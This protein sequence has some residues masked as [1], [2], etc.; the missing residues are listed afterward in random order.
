MADS[1]LAR[2][3][4]LLENRG[5]ILS[6]LKKYPNVVNLGV[7]LKEV[8]GKLTCILCYRV[9]VREKKAITKLMS[10]DIIPGQIDGFITDVIEY[11]TVEIAMD[12][13]PYRPLTGGVQIKNQYWVDNKTRGGGTLGCLVLN[14]N[15][16]DDEPDRIVGLTNEHV[17]ALNTQDTPEDNE[18][19]QPWKHICCCCCVKNVVGSVLRATKNNHLD[20]AVINLHDDIIAEIK[21]AGGINKIAEIGSYKGKAIA[22][23]GMKVKKRG[24]AT[25][26]T[27]GIVKDVAFDSNQI[28]IGPDENY[29]RFADFGD[30]GSIVLN[31]DDRIV[32]LLWATERNR[33]RIP[34]EPVIL[35]GNI[36][37]KIDPRIHGVATPI[38]VVETEMKIKI[39]SPPPVTPTIAIHPSDAKTF[40]VPSTKAG[41]TK[42]H[43]VTV[44]GDGDIILKVTFDQPVDASRVKWVSDNETIAISTPGDGT[45]PFTA[46]MSR[47]TPVGTMANISVTVDGYVVGDPAAVWIIWSSVLPD[48]KFFSDELKFTITPL[49]TSINYSAVLRYTI[50]PSYIIAPDIDTHDLPDLRGANVT[51]APNVPDSDSGV[52]QKGTDLSPGATAKWDGS[53]RLRC[54]GIHPGLF[55]PD[56]FNGMF[57]NY[58]S[59]PLVGNFDTSSFPDDSPY[60]SITVGKI[61]HLTTVFYELQQN[62]GITGDK[63]EA[64][65]QLQEF[66]RLELGGQW[67]IISDNL[68]WRL[69]V[70]LRKASEFTDNKDYDGDGL[71]TGEAWID[72]GTEAVGNNDNF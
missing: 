19:G 69:H 40:L 60:T 45:D 46:K 28:L 44:K 18:I 17:A 42:K 7:G 10:D 49:E 34:H 35:S 1:L 72:N 20:C 23:A 8:Q 51:P 30:S 59:D 4:T 68:L 55:L 9:Y 66:A 52:F 32:G 54:K 16:D 56:G 13:K 29:E 71:K 64:H 37:T 39:P 65:I 36:P 53:V 14:N 26:L 47:A 41:S 50:Q 22:T 3:T 5:R 27:H 15:P 25:G 48:D 31:A 33:F 57:P 2:Q 63:V 11:G 38:D 67:F 62:V 6:K 70:K 58:P 24:A 61:S 21:S 12:D 43:F